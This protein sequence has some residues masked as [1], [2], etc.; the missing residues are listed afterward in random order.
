DEAR[1]ALKNSVSDDKVWPSRELQG[2]HNYAADE[3][4]RA[5]KNS[6]SDDKVWPSRELQ[7]SHNYA[8]DE[9]RRA[10]KNSVSDDKVWPSR[11]LQGSHNY[12]ADEARRALKNFVSYDMYSRALSDEGHRQGVEEDKERR[13]SEEE[14]EYFRRALT[15][16]WA[17][18]G[19]NDERRALTKY[20]MMERRL[21]APFSFRRLRIAQPVP[22]P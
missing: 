6:V 2:S 20:D 19:D 12:A 22:S 5:L 17:P 15:A 1:R 9:A 13:T 18:V 10:L 7:G 4:R 14:V 8:A 11:E 21:K 16:F 3:A